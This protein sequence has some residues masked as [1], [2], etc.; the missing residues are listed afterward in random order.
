MK[1][2]SL[3]I[4]T[5][6]LVNTTFAQQE[7]YDALLFSQ[8]YY[9]STA[10][11]AAMGGA[12]GALGSEMGAIAV[13]PAAIVTY[14]TNELIFTPE[15]YRV[16]STT[17][18]Y[19]QLN[20]RFKNGV[21]IN[22]AG[23]VFAIQPRRSSTRYNIGFAYNKQNFFNANERINAPNVP[24]EESYIG[25]VA[26]MGN[27]RDEQFVDDHKELGDGKYLFNQD[28]TLYSALLGDIGQRAMYTTTGHVGEYAL[29]FGANI[30]E[31]IYLGASFIVRD[32]RKS[33]VAELNEESV[34]DTDYRYS[35]NRMYNL[36]GL[37]FGGRVGIL[38]LPIPE[39]SIG[40]SLQVPTFYSFTKRSEG[41]MIFPANSVYGNDSYP[42]EPENEIN[43]NLVTPLQLALSLGYVFPE[44]AS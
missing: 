34:I 11:S 36:S 29:S 38:I 37:G 13:N 26:K 8:P 20:S 21:N 42:Y 17:N 3:I 30:S 12:S 18:Y 28:G 40:L 7:A 22:N 39:F 41:K 14:K 27:E 2:T 43:Y 24:S 15:F 19:D 6:F 16:E 33:F 35:Y 1:K 44:V 23:V 32:S 31:K 4:A 9:F 25:Q 5:L 10:R